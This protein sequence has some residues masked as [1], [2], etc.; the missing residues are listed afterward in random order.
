V[1]QHALLFWKDKQTEYN[2]SSTVEKDKKLVV[3][4]TPDMN[5]AFEFFEDKNN[6]RFVEEAMEELKKGCHDKTEVSLYPGGKD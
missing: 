4:D 1:L 3:E 5:A 6:I 2:K